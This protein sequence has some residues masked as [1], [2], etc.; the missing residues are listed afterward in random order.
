MLQQSQRKTRRPSSNSGKFL[1]AFVAVALTG[2]G[3]TKL[4]GSVAGSCEIYPSPQY[5]VVGKTQYDQDTIDEYVAI[6]SDVCG[7]ARPAA[8]PPELDGKQPGEV[9]P[10]PA[11]RKRPGIGAK[12][13]KQISRMNPL[14]PAH[15]APIS[16]PAGLPT[17]GAPLPT[18]D[19]PAAAPAP[20]PSVTK[21]A[22]DPLTELLDPS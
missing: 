12:L 5:A 6:G 16:V 15:A 8:R 17:V 2:C 14:R 22:R 3:T 9:T 10:V 19:P 1:L 20:A 11:P 4:P 13:R 21:P 7:K 18:T